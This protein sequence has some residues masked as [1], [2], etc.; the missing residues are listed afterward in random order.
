MN[1][2]LASSATP[3]SNGVGNGAVDVDGTAFAAEIIGVNGKVVTK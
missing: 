1:P 3:P 2:P